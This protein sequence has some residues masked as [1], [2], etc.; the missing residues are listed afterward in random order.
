V[1]EWSRVMY[2]RPK[3]EVDAE[4]ATRAQFEDPPVQ[5]PF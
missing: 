4:I 2:G 1:R 5:R 3:A